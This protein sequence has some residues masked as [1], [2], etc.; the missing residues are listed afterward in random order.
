[1]ISVILHSSLT[2]INLASVWSCTERINAPDFKDLVNKNI[3]L[4]ILCW[5]FA[6]MVMFGYVGWNKIQ[7]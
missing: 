4:L 3:L 5:L 7:Y 2:L 6:E 1:M